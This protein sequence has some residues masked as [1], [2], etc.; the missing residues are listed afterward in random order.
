GGHRRAA[1]VGA[2]ATRHPLLV[3][4]PDP[5]EVA[6]DAGRTR[7]Q[8][9]ARRDRITLER[10]EGTVRA[11]QF[12]LVERPAADAGHEDLPYARAMTR[13]HGV[14]AAVPRV[15]VADD[16]HAPRVR[17]PDREVHAGRALV[18]DAM[19]A[20]LV[21]EPGVRTLAEEP[22]IGG[23]EHGSEPV[24]VLDHP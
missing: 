15:E 10:Q 6:D 11:E 16:A 24:R 1:L 18:R 21:I 9:G 22:I 8:L 2:V 12:V 7:P 14:P 17:R 20:K 23:A 3:V 19:R 5:V 13:S 4:P